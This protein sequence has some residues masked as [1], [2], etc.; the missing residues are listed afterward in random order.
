MGDLEMGCDFR[1]IF[2]YN[3]SRYL[4]QQAKRFEDQS[5]RKMFAQEVKYKKVKIYSHCS[6][7][8]TARRMIAKTDAQSPDMFTGN[9]A[10][11]STSSRIRLRKIDRT[12][13]LNDAEYMPRLAELF[14]V[15][16][17]ISF[18]Q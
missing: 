15:K 12:L 3:R 14:S 4:T 1:Q 10:E 13:S 7:S 17:L 16:R 6:L 5:C 8:R 18:T 9:S 2:R 11:R